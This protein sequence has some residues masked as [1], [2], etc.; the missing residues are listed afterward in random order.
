MRFQHDS[1]PAK[2]LVSVPLLVSLLLLTCCGTLDANRESKAELGFVY[3]QF[4]TFK[5]SLT[6]I[7]EV[8]VAGDLYEIIGETYRR[9]TTGLV[10]FEGTA[11][12]LKTCLTAWD[13]T[14]I[15]AGC[16]RIEHHWLIRFTQPYGVAP[17]GFMM[18]I[19]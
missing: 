11:W 8:G 14:I 17:V 3:G 15:H 2:V 9:G 5:R 12:Q 6:A 19:L 13:N 7:N 18:P 1:C 10:R 4:R 16:N